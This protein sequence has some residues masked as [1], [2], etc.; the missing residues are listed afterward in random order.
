M[1][2]RWLGPALRRAGRQTVEAPVGLCHNVPG[3]LVRM[4]PFL[5]LSLPHSYLFLGN[6]KIS[7]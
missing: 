3:L 6:F 7:Y 5:R 4:I 2:P 1:S